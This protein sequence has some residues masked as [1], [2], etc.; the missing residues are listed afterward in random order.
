MVRLKRAS[1]FHST[2]IQFEQCSRGRDTRRVSSDNSSRKLPSEK[3]HWQSEEHCHKVRFYLGSSEYDVN[4]YDG[5]DMEKHSPRPHRASE[6]KEV[7]NI[8][9]HEQQKQPHATG[10]A[11]STSQNHGVFN[12]FSLKHLFVGGGKSKMKT[13]E[14]DAFSHSLCNR[15]PG[16]AIDHLEIENDKLSNPEK[17]FPKCAEP[18]SKQENSTSALALS[19]QNVNIGGDQKPHHASKS[20][21][22]SS[23]ARSSDMTSGADSSSNLAP[24]D[25]HLLSRVLQMGHVIG[26]GLRRANSTRH[27]GVAV[28]RCQGKHRGSLD[29]PRTQLYCHPNNDSNYDGEDDGVDDDEE[30]FP[31]S[32]ADESCL[33]RG[34]SFMR[35]HFPHLYKHSSNKATNS[36]GDN[37]QVKYSHDKSHQHHYHHHHHHQHHY[38]HHHHHRLREYVLEV[39]H[40]PH[41]L[42]RTRKGFS[43]TTFR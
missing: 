10:K 3:G 36:D 7:R 27:R 32:F 35:R 20:T 31:H 8:R 14:D 4:N 13:E 34:D 38:H 24:D 39:L 25:H 26:R 11:H 2:H 37:K 18:A 16:P 5:L 42:R 6:A 9:S 19:S 41:R 43:Q 1:T 30:F 17:L 40:I 12:I 22:M 28:A 23:A 21:N 15:E 33:R 29:K